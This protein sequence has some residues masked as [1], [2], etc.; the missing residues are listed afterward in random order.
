M[1]INYYIDLFDFDNGEPILETEELTL[2]EATAI[3]NV[4]AEN[5][6]VIYDRPGLCINLM[7]IVRDPSGEILDT[8]EIKTK[9]LTRD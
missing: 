8:K 1:N 2:E 4:I 9:F 3:F 5:A 6:V 7:E